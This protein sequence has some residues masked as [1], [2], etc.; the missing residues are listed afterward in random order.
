MNTKYWLVAIL[1]LFSFNTV[2]ADNAVCKKLTL[3]ESISIAVAKNLDINKR[4]KDY[5]IA[6]NNIKYA[7]RLLN[8]QF[9][10]WFYFGDAAFGAPDMF[11]VEFPIEIM[12]RGSRVNMAKSE[13]ILTG[14]SI[15]SDTFNL[16]M[17]VRTAYIAYAGAKSVVKIIEQQQ[18]YLREMVAI[19]SK[20]V[21]VGVAPDI[22]YMQ[23]KIILEQLTTTYNKA[24]A[25]VEVEQYN[26]NKTL[27][28]EENDL[29]YCIIDDELPKSA[30][31]LKLS[32]PNPKSQLPS[33]EYVEKIGFNNRYDI[34][35]A[36]NEVEVAKKNLIVICRKKIPDISIIAGYLY[37]NDEKNRDIT[38]N[39]GDALHGFYAGLN[40]DLPVFYRYQPEIKNAKIEIDKKVL[41]LK[42]VENVAKQN[43]KVAYTRLIVAQKNLN[44][45]SD[46]L[47]KNSS[48]V[49]KSSK[50]SYEV[51]KTDLSNLI[52]IQQ[53]NTSILMGYTM[54][55]IEYYFA[56]INLLK[57]LGVE[58]IN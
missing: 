9:Q 51:G 30:D 56:W 55:L 2:W 26:F 13:K 41:N 44:Y 8:P 34:K 24:L 1:L 20:R 16:K 49:V 35:V 19:A 29:L 33:Y 36:S 10:S 57:E 27:N 22:E 40:V 37:L 54:A 6:T 39:N 53:S 28:V 32:T 4:R 58:V 11:G 18:E 46:E 38:L 48:N 47:L 31:F 45:Y 43:I 7:N 52:L 50:R 21:F 23:A 12:K 17:D 15:N 25:Q 3:E 14:T 42:S 5:D